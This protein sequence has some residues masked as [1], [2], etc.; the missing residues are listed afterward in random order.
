MTK[1]F[2]N[3]G[4]LWFTLTLCMPMDFSIK[5]HT[6]KSGWSIVYIEGPKIILIFIL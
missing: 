5:F 3:L 1:P 6:V 4:Q 2:Y